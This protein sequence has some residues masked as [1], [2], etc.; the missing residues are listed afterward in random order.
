[1]LDCDEVQNGEEKH[2]WLYSLAEG[3]NPDAL[4]P[5]SIP[6]TSPD[7]APPTCRDD[8]DNDDGEAISNISYVGVAEF[9]EVSGGA[10]PVCPGRWEACTNANCLLFSGCVLADGAS[11]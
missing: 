6:E 8:N 10:A 7:S 9:G 5:D 3:I 2:R 1:M 4:D 11:A